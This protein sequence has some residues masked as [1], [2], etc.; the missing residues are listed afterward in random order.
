MAAKRKKNV[1]KMVARLLREGLENQ[2]FPGA[3]VGIVAGPVGH[4]KTWFI[5]EGCTSF[6]AE[7]SAVD[8]ATV[9]DLA[10]LTKP[11]AT[12]LAVLCLLRDR[13][14]SLASGLAALLGQAVPADK[15]AITLRQLLCHQAGL[16]AHREF[17]K[18]FHEFDREATGPAMLAMVLAEPLEHPPGRRT[19]YSD[20]G[21][22]LLGWAVERLAGQRLDHFVRERIYAPMGLCDHLFFVPTAE[23]VGHGATIFACTENCPWRQRVLC[24]EVSDDNAWVLGGVAGQAGLFGDIVGVTTLVGHILDQWQGREEPCAYDGDTLRSF[25]RRPEGTEAGARALGFDTPAPTGSSGGALISPA[26]VGHLGFTGTSF[27]M[28]PERDAAVVLLTNRVHPSRENEL[29]KEFRPRL[30]D[31]VWSMLDTGEA[32]AQRHKGTKGQRP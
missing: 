7:R 31:A 15:D 24:G 17:Y 3:A 14:L 1:E 12:T 19:V 27:W 18:K 20:L 8:K 30:H 10:S 22:L 16:P 5:T 25:L 29:I 4:G 6:L 32:E 26:S 11:L 21:F 13:R 28:D 23:R 9:F 2:V